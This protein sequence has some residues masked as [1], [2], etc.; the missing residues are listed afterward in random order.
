MAFLSRKSAAIY[1]TAESVEGTAVDPSVD[2]DSISVNVDGFEVNGDK[3]L[4]ERNVLR[5]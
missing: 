3:E 2:D 4:V 1:V 5:S